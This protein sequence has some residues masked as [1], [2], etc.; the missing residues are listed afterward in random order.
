MAVA[1]DQFFTT[2]TFSPA[3]Q[4]KT[5]LKKYTDDLAVA[6]KK[7]D[8]D[9]AFRLG[10]GF[11]RG[12]FGLPVD[13]TKARE[14]LRMAITWKNG[15]DDNSEDEVYIIDSAERFCFEQ[16]D[17]L[18]E[19]LTYE[20]IGGKRYYNEGSYDKIRY[21]PSKFLYAESV[22]KRLNEGKIEA[23]LVDSAQ[24]GIVKD[25]NEGITRNFVP[26]KGML[27]LLYCS[28]FPGIPQNISKGLSLLKEAAELGDGPSKLALGHAYSTPLHCMQKNLKEACKWYKAAEDQ[29]IAQASPELKAVMKEIK[30]GQCVLL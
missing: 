27:G 20:E 26:A 30:K 10:M 25:L 7:G 1:T 19:D 8:Y 4:G 6:A 23:H 14:F 28:G 29:G 9:A 22:Y 16:K 13:M 18:G 11:T 21:I 5:A 17:L 3:S 2:L 24:K 15:G 12:H